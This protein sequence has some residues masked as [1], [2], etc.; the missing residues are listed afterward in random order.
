VTS[1]NRLDA[2]G[3]RW[4]L[5]P[6]QLGRLARVLDVLAAD[7]AAPTAVRG[8]TAL[9]V[10]VADSLTALALECVTRARTIADLGSGA[11]FPGVVLAI[12]L[13]RSRVA[14]VESAGRKCEFL[15]GLCAGLGVGNAEVVYARAE[16]WTAGLG[17]HDLVVARAVAALPVLCEY[18]APLL[19]PGGSLVAWKGAVAPEERTAGVRAAA[20][21]GLRAERAVRTE[22]YP[23]SVAHHL[24]EYRKLAPTPPGFPRRAGLARRR[25]LGTAG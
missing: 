18:A 23:G 21:L 19:A 1:A 2:L 12:A 8:A 7:P 22:P 4:K 25:P 13:P 9:D 14:L 10:H 16:E 5:D 24:Y 17:A 20:T 6:R 11:G 15:R 3:A